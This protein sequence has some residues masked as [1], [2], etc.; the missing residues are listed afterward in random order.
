MPKKQRPLFGS[1]GAGGVRTSS[2]MSASRLYSAREQYRDAAKRASRD[3]DCLSE[4]AE[5]AAAAIE[6]T[7]AATTEGDHMTVRISGPFDDWFGVDVRAI[8]NDIEASN[9]S[10]LRLL[11]ES[12]GG[13]LND[14]IAFY[15][16]LRERAEEH[17]VQITAETRGLVA[18]AAVLPYLAADT[19]KMTDGSTLMIHDAWTRILMV[20]SVTEMEAEFQKAIKSMKAMN[21]S[22]TRIMA[23][24]VG[25]P[26]ATMSKWMRDE[27]WMDASEAFEHNFATEELEASDDDDKVEAM[28]D[29]EARAALGNFFRAA[30]TREIF[31]AHKAQTEGGSHAW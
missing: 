11:I 25:V 7:Y 14:G 24:R 3:F 10:S 19:R 21:S 15:E 8:Q 16:F 2:D 31:S 1:N 30:H 18:S 5:V 20:G 13:I 26:T 27:M 12:P 29:E 28:T 17:N 6:Q 9:P 23:S 4:D 22:L